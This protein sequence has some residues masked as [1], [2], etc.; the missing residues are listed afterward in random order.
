MRK[1]KE[2]FAFFRMRRFLHPSD[3][4][5]YG[6]ADIND[7]T[8]FKNKMQTNIAPLITSTAQLISPQFDSP[9]AMNLAFSATGLSALGVTDDLGDS[10]FSV[11][12]SLM[13]Q[14]W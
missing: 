13:L 8:S 4:F 9:F 3:L 5:A 11:A 2:L 10:S 12:S 14:I 6:N 7:P 1:D